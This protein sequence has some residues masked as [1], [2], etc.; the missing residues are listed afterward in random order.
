MLPNLDYEKRLQAL[1]RFMHEIRGDRGATAAAAWPTAPAFSGDGTAGTF[2]YTQQTGYYVLDGPKVDIWGRCAISAIAVNPTGNMRII[3]LPFAAS[4][5]T[6][7]FAVIGLTTDNLD[8]DAGF[9]MVKG[10]INPG[11]QFMYIIE[12]GDNAVRAAIQGSTF[13]NNV[14]VDIVFSGSYRI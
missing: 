3:N 12:S 5:D 2:T 8:Y 14:A 1:E 10:Q 6:N 9:T 13:D 11:A 7:N 4:A